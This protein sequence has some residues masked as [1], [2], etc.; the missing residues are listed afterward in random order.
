MFTKWGNAGRD[1]TDLVQARH[2]CKWLE[3]R[4]GATPMYV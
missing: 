4:K 3:L 2:H 1:L